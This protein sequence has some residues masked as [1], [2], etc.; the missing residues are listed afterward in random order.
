MSRFS[1]L[2]LLAA[3]AACA[4]TPAAVPGPAASA[5]AAQAPGAPRVL[6]VGA[7]EAP[8]AGAVATTVL[9]ESPTSVSRVMRLAPGAVI[10]EH[11][12]PVH[13]ETF[14]VH[15]GAVAA[16]LDGREHSL[17]A[18]DLVHIPAGTVIA[19]RN[20]GPAEA[21]L[22]VVFSSTGRPGPLTAPGHPQH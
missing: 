20:A 16:T 17:R 11:H 6:G 1:P 5:P 13:D 12:H 22:V 8:A 10:P 21:V 2:P 4:P 19:G 9:S 15:Q 18:G 14:F 7:A 3:L